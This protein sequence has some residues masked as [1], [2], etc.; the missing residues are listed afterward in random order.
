MG[1]MLYALAWEFWQEAWWR[2]LVSVS[3][4]AATMMFMHTVV[5]KAGGG[6]V[7]ANQIDPSLNVILVFAPFVLWAGTCCAGSLCDRSSGGGL[8]Q[9][10]YVLPIATWVLAV[11]LM[12]LCLVFCVLSMLATI[13]LFGIWSGT[14]P[15]LAWGTVLFAGVVSA[16]GNAIVWSTSGRHLLRVAAFSS[17]LVPLATWHAQ[18]FGERVLQMSKVWTSPTFGEYLF[19]ALCTAAVCAVSIVGVSFDR[20]GDRGSWSALREWWDRRTMCLARTKPFDSPEAAQAWCLWRRWGW[21]MPAAV[22]VYLAVELLLFGVGILD[23]G[24]ALA[25]FLFFSAFGITWGAVAFGAVMGQSIAYKGKPGISPFIATRPVSDS[26]LSKAALKAAGLSFFLTWL[27]YVLIVLVV[28]VCVLAFV[29]KGDA[30]VDENFWRGLPFVH[31]GPVLSGKSF[32]GVICLIGAFIAVGWTFLGLTLSLALTG[33]QRFFGGVFL[34][35]LCFLLAFRVSEVFEFRFFVDLVK[36]A[37]PWVACLGC[38]GGTVLLFVW[39]RQRDLIGTRL[40]GIACLWLVLVSILALH[41]FAT[42]PWEPP[43]ADLLY[44]ASMWALPAIPF[45][46]APLA[47]AW[48]R[49]R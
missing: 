47:L 17:V 24:D 48:N 36:R 23:A 45:A 18:R 40:A 19:M 22:A 8:S 27:A 14:P 13:L 10:L 12:T 11:W 33:R 1:R 41:E 21:V 25:G 4:L 26:F 34:G 42:S 37:G 15:L 32:W 28:V 3:F 20:R 30:L 9:R 2:V 6:Y 31:G 29:S 39:A 7:D 38:L 44:F 49:H 16:A 35:G 5:V 43:L 46:A